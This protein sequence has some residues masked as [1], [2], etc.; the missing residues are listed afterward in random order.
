MSLNKS[1]K[2]CSFK[3]NGGD[4][5]DEN[6]GTMTTYYASHN[7]ITVCNICYHLASCHSS[8]SIFPRIS[9]EEGQGH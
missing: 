6:S 8:Y 3:V 9:N 7:S 4:F 1:L 2:I 5:P